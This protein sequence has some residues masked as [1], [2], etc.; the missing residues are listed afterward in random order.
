MNHTSKRFNYQIEDR[1]YVVEIRPF[2]NYHASLHGYLI[3][4]Y[5][6][7]FLIGDYQFFKNTVSYELFGS[8]EDELMDYLFKY[9]KG[10]IDGWDK[11][12]RSNFKFK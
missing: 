12:R 2:I 4:V 5:H 8:S 6:Q 11:Y 3:S 10:F 7:D 1:D 9:S